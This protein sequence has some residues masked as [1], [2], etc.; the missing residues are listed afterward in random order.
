MVDGVSVVV[1]MVEDKCVRVYYTQPE[2]V[3][4]LHDP[5][6]DGNQFRRSPGKALQISIG[7]R[8]GDEDVDDD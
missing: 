1:T 5:G 3:F 4:R 8:S 2:P 6:A 7:K